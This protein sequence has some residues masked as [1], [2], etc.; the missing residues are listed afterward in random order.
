MKKMLT[1]LLAGLVS[2]HASAESPDNLVM[3][4]GGNFKNT[5][6]SY[7]GKGITV[8]DFYIGKY[9][10]TQK[11]WMEVMGSAPS[12]FK[13]NDLPVECVSWYDCIEYCNNRSKKTGLIPYYTIDKSKKDPTN[14]HPG[15]PLKW[16]VTTNADA[17]GYRLPTEPEWEYASG[18]G[19][20]SKNYTYSGSDDPDKVAWY[21]INSGDQRQKEPWLESI[22]ISNHC[23]T[24]PVGSKA[25]NE[26]G[27]YDMSGN[28]REWCWDWAR[29][30]NDDSN[31][32]PAKPDAHGIYRVWRGAC[33]MSGEEYCAS[34]YRDGYKPYGKASDQG[35]RVCRSAK[36]K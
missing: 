2:V 3:V 19:Q 28:V 13:G 17:N 23:R 5:K 18:G 24:R 7:Y 32:L 29:N 34:S 31:A 25:P 10:V 6:S 15:D 27:L 12:K 1:I 22:L 21:W 20:L 16:I 11:E 14:E 30:N 9:E 36:S 26:L 4:P 33:W 35:F 8:S